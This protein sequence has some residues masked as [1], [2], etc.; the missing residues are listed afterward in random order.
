MH[1]SYS[2]GYLSPQVSQSTY[3]VDSLS[4]RIRGNPSVPQNQRCIVNPLTSTTVKSKTKFVLFSKKFIKIKINTSVTCATWNIRQYNFRISLFRHLNLG[5]VPVTSQSFCHTQASCHQSLGVLVRPAS[6]GEPDLQNTS[7]SSRC[8]L[9]CGTQNE[10]QATLALY[11]K[12]PLDCEL[13]G[14]FII[15]ALRAWLRKATRTCHNP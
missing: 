14:D 1:Q 8:V 11:S 4:L 12:M 13:R 15:S 5:L 6:V 2:S 3:S 9:W 7:S 10:S